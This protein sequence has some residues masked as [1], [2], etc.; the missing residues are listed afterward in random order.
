MKNNLSN[1]IGNKIRKVGELQNVTREK[2]AA[3]LGISLNGYGKIE[4]NETDP[5]LKRLEQIADILKVDV[6]Q[7]INFDEKQVFNVNNSN[8]A[9]GSVQNQNNVSSELLENTITM[10]KETMSILKEENTNLMALI[11]QL[12]AK[13]NL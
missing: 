7:L 12:L 10:M 6:L 5:T 2:I 9:Y 11:S 8:F 1:S 13:T 3:D 4:R